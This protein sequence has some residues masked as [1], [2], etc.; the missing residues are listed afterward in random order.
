MPVLTA[1]QA[2]VGYVSQPKALII[3]KDCHIIVT[4]GIRVNRTGGGIGNSIGGEGDEEGG[5]A[6]GPLGVALWS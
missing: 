6:M 1:L 3:S 2:R 5:R 4:E